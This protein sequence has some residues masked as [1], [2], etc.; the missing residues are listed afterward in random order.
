M[1]VE[2]RQNPFPHFTDTTG[3]PLANGYV[4]FGEANQD[5]RQYPVTV[6]YDRGLTIPATQ[7][8]RT[9]AGYL[10]RNGS[11]ANVYRNG[12]CSVMVLDS[13]QRQV[14]YAA[15]WI[16]VA[17]AAATGAAAAAAPY[18][19]AAAV[20]A[21]SAQNYADIAAA[22][23]RIYSSGALGDAGTTGT[24]YYYVVSAFSA[25]TLE[26]W[27]HNGSG[28]IDTGKRL[29]SSKLI[30]DAVWG[31]AGVSREAW[32]Q[33]DAPSGILILGDSFVRGLG[34]TD[35]E[36]DGWPALLED[37][38]KALLGD[39]GG[40]YYG[41]PLG[42]GTLSANW[43][44][45]TLGGTW[46]GLGE[47]GP[48]GGILYAS[49]NGATASLTVD[50]DT[51]TILYQEF[52]LSG[53]FTVAVD[54]GSAVTYGT[55]TSPASLTPKTVEISL[56][57]T[58]SHTIVITNATPGR[59]F[60]L[61]GV[62]A[63]NSAGGPVIYRMGKD[64]GTAFTW[65]QWEN[66]VTHVLT[67]SN[68]YYIDQLQPQ[69]TIIALGINDWNF[70]TSL[71]DYEVSLRYLIEKA[72]LYGHVL[73]VG[74]VQFSSI[75]R[76]ITQ[77][78]Y[79]DVMYDLATEYDCAYLD[80][81]ARWGVFREGVVRGFTTTL[82]DG[83]PSDAGAQDFADAVFYKITA[84]PEPA[85]YTT[86]DAPTLAAAY[87]TRVIAD[88]GIVTNLTSVVAAF[89]FGIANGITTTARYSPEWG[90]KKDGS[91]KISKLYALEG[92][93]YDLVQATGASQP[94]WVS[95]AQNSYPAVRCAGG[96]F[97][98]SSAFTLYQPA[99][100]CLAVKQTT[101]VSGRYLYDGLTASSGG[102]AQYSVTP[103]I[104]AIAGVA[105]T[106]NAN[107]AVGAWS[108]VRNTMYAAESEL[109]VNGTMVTAGNT[110]T[111]TP[112][113]F[114]LGAGATGLLPVNADFGEVW[115][116]KLPQTLAQKDA[117]YAYFKRKWNT[118]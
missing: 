88:G 91:N 98:A 81:P 65:A 2:A 23:Q 59:Y 108:Y 95:A 80:M 31:L 89:E 10:Y 20:S 12:N 37:Q 75:V 41:E 62:A 86:A 68:L 112:G 61:V 64:G 18:A 50:G 28:G 11:P 3:N 17:D 7:P 29:P 87:Q 101:W 35:P 117:L 103:N 47:G 78:Q 69:L 74:S 40:G 97:L 104:I 30:R 27:Q 94:L 99:T 58:G 115:I 71:A 6:Y 93:A 54:G 63:V 43:E 42:A 83:H 48:G 118:A 8:L 110:G 102:L 51:L 92:A 60:Y 114:T 90:V 77:A 113:G 45:M 56:G 9:T 4:Y 116:I 70:Q 46:T 106:E 36:T 105:G 19:A 14:S 38:L 24:Q 76:T 85:T 96:P 5:P 84:I 26:L 44:K 22:A 53:Q 72:Q 57:G 66:T 1:T 55:V 79:N 100:V 25:N 39:G 73:L 15:E 13:A 16:G 33:T 109:Q 34:T 111:N 107:L 82:T 32:S 67:P 52:N 49:S 21:A